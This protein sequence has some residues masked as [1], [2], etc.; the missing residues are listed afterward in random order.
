VFW[1]LFNQV[2]STWVVQGNKMTTFDLFGY[3]VDG[4]RMQAAG[5]IL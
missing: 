3:Q 1:A 5:S 2:D 4:E